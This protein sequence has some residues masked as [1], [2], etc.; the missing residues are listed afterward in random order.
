VRFVPFAG[1]SSSAERSV[2]DR[3]AEGPIP[4]TPTKLPII[5]KSVYNKYMAA[6]ATAEIT[7]DPSVDNPSS[8]VPP[9]VDAKASFLQKLGISDADMVQVRPAS[10]PALT[11]P[12]PIRV[13]KRTLSEQEQYERDLRAEQTDAALKE[14]AETIA[15]ADTITTTEQA[16]PD[17]EPTAA[18]TP[19]AETGLFAQILQE[20][21]TATGAEIP[22]PPPA[23]EPETIATPPATNPEQTTAAEPENA[24]TPAPEAYK[25][26]DIPTGLRIGTHTSSLNDSKIR[27]GQAETTVVT[28]IPEAP[29]EPPV[30]PLLSRIA[31]ASERANSATTTATEQATPSIEPVVADAASPAPESE[32]LAA[33]TVAEQSAINE[34]LAQVSQPTA[35]ETPPLAAQPAEVAAPEVAPAVEEPAE[36]TQVSFSLTA[37]PNEV[38][39]GVPAPVVEP[40]APAIATLSD[41]AAMIAK[42]TALGI[43]ATQVAN[44]VGFDIQR[45]NTRT[46]REKLADLNP[47]R[48]KTASS[49]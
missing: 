39:G 24:T 23:P 16:A 12:Q 10:E 15:P 34:A 29:S 41:E 8:G 14:L 27:D 6:E 19:A 36:E 44:S 37:Q 45:R 22:T 28:A 25:F 20:R 43:N 33:S 30:S 18:D 5:D 7:V 21:S 38:M 2:R 4:F 32:D 49:Q 13:F 1:C 47:L 46:W 9:T 26:P 42:Q 11:E 3:E 31:A 48:R 35:I 17:V 40:V